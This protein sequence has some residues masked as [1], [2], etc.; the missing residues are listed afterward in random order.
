MKVGFVVGRFQCTNFHAGYEHFF[1][2]ILSFNDKFSIVLSDSPIATSIRNPFTIQERVTIIQSQLIKLRLMDRFIGFVFVKDHSD[3]GVWS[4]NLDS[5]LLEFVLKLTPKLNEQI[6]VTLCGGRDSFLSKYSG[7]FA[8]RFI[9]PLPG[10]HSSTDTRNLDL[11]LASIYFNSKAYQVGKI[12]ALAQQ[13]PKVFSTVDIAIL[14]EDRTLV[15]LGRK[16][17]EQKWRFPGGFV[18]PTDS[19]Y[20]MAALREAKEECGK[21]ILNNCQ[22]VT[23]QKIDDWRYRNERDKIITTFFTATYVAGQ[24]EASDDLEEV[25]WFELKLILEL[26]FLLN[27][28][29]VLF[30]K[31]IQFLENKKR[32]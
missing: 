8:T 32:K 6:N 11:Q 23:S 31:L 24:V 22:Y 14:S 3:D 10:D 4:T 1:S 2:E 30:I 28:H 15:L 26:D 16:P 18:D 25:K 19:S 27:G 29:R 12:A 17:G 7:K 20:E 9:N 21:I 5:A 13:F